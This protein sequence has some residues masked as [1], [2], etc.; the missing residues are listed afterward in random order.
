[1]RAEGV[2]YNTITYNSTID[3]CVKCGNLSKGVEIFQEMREQGKH[4]NTIIYTTLIKGYGMDKDLTKALELFHEMRAEGVPYNTITYNSIIDACIKSQDL[5][6]AEALM[7]EMTRPES[8]LEPDLITFSTLLKGYC[9]AGNI[10]K[11]LQ[12]AE[13]IKARGLRCDE[14]VYNTLMDGCVKESDIAAGVGLF[15]EMVNAGLRPSAITHGILTR[16]YQKV[17]SEEVAAEA[18]AQLYQQ[19]G[20][21]RP[22]GDRARGGY[23]RG[24]KWANPH[25][26]SP[27]GHRH[28]DHGGHQ[29]P[30][31]SSMAGTPYGGTPS[32]YGSGHR[33]DACWWEHMQAMPGYDM[34]GQSEP[35]TPLAGGYIPSGLSNSP[36]M[37]M[38]AFGAPMMPPLPGFHDPT[39]FGGHRSPDNS[40]GFG[41]CQPQ[42]SGQPGGPPMAT[43]LGPQ[44]MQQQHQHQQHQQQHQQQC[45]QM[46]QQHQQPQQQLQQQQS[47]QP[48]LP[49]FPFP[50]SQ[51]PGSDGSFAMPSYNTMTT[52]MMTPPMPVHGMSPQEFAHLGVTATAPAAGSGAGSSG[53]PGGVNMYPEAYFE[54]WTAATSTAD[55]GCQS[56]GPVSSM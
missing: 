39:G 32:G 19:H 2:P 54:N 28:G 51:T 9:Y 13:A 11:A 5:K 49:L 25:Q 31:S 12:V 4:R 36:F 29:T 53:T 52:P 40:H 22:T 27:G 37:Q 33:D 43:A 45:Q 26:R 23:G 55:S 8:T 6:Q 10:D 20:I 47:P 34:M 50:A 7:C 35:S 21:E 44:L 15:E 48:M 24:N 38:D 17:G 1:M 42:M 3:V 46:Q 30:S 16:L 41:F 18:V 14:L 56:Q